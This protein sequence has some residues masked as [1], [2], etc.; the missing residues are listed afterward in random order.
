MA[1]AYSLIWRVFCNRTFGQR[2]EIIR[3][4]YNFTGLPIYPWSTQRFVHHKELPSSAA[5]PCHGNHHFCLTVH[6]T[7]AGFQNPNF[8]NRH[9]PN[10]ARVIIYG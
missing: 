4:I 2:L 3:G 8:P 1:S 6:S 9:G 7:G 10:D 5:V